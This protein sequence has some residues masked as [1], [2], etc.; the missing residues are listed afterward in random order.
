MLAWPPVPA[1]ARI[2]YVGEIR[3]AADLKAPKKIFESLGT[4]LLGP[5]K[6]Q[7][8][9]GPRSVTSTR[10]GRRIWVADP[11][12][13]RVH[14]FD[15]DR[16]TY[17][18]INRVGE[19]PLLTPV[20]VCPGPGESVFICDSE[21]VAIFRVRESDATLI[22]ALRLPE[23]LMRP[24]ALHFDDDRHELYV[25]DAVAHRVVVLDPGGRLLRIIGGRGDQPGRFNFP[26]DI[27]QNDDLIW[28]VDSG[29][30]RVQGLTPHG[31]PVA[32][33]GTPG[34]APGDLALPKS[35]AFDGDGHAYVVDARF[36]NVQVFDR[37][38]RLLL[39]FGQE[40][41]GPGEFWLPS[42]IHIDPTDRI[43]ICDSYNRRL[44]VFQY[45]TDATESPPGNPAGASPADSVS[46]GETFTEVK[47]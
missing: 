32:I 7:P 2:R 35:I 31:E 46:D 38:G 39:F 45:L 11:G 5:Q 36:E 34:D 42:G 6:T 40:G 37:T 20:D 19:T 33:F 16:R 18:E 3:R 1:P 41:T 28:V 13:R 4:L 14:M 8:L 10:Q 12:G 17:L 29:N 23:E 26:C 44:Q 43:W 25:V 15:L 21:N 27:A 9:Y 24:V 47:P 30:Q 22:E